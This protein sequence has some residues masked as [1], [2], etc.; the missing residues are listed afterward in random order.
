LEE[1]VLFIVQLILS[2]EVLNDDRDSERSELVVEMAGR[3]AKWREDCE[4]AG[5]KVL[6][7]GGKEEIHQLFVPPPATRTRTQPAALKVGVRSN[8]NMWP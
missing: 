4:M 6:R 3:I 2:I 8:N 5:R 7:N 1:E